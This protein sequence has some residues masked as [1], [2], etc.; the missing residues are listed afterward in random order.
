ML[1]YN[2]RMHDFYSF[3]TGHVTLFG[4]ATHNWVIALVGAVAIWAVVLVKDL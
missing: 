3:M 1:T 4:V 2:A